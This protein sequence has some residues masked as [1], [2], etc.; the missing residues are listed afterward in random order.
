MT[1]ISQ[2]VDELHGDVQLALYLSKNLCRI[3]NKIER[4][5]IQLAILPSDAEA[6][7]SS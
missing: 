4:V 6:G 5:T 1:Q 7:A 3:V 2:I